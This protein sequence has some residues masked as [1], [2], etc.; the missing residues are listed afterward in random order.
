MT[1]SVNIVHHDRPG[2]R[3]A[4]PP[5]GARLLDDGTGDTPV[6]EDLKNAANPANWLENQLS[7]HSRSA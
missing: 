1:L 3:W 5:P 4:G 7:A 6:R 2:G